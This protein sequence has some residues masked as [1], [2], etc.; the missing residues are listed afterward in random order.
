MERLRVIEPCK[1]Q[2][3]IVTNRNG[4]ATIAGAGGEIFEEAGVLN[5]LPHRLLHGPDSYLAGSKVAVIFRHRAPSIWTVTLHALPTAL[6]RLS[7]S[8]FAPASELA[9]AWATGSAA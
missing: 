4:P 1:R 5:A 6:W 3:R 9:N 7:G 2:D 8:V